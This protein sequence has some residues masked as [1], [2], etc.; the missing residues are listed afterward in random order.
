[1]P[2][3]PQK[4]VQLNYSAI[5]IRRGRLKRWLLMFLILL[6]LILAAGLSWGLIEIRK[7]LRMYDGKS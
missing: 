2:E 1:M 5:E 7:L 3:D 4:P 6:S